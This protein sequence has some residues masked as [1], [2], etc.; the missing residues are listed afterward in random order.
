MKWNT[1]LEFGEETTQEKY[2]FPTDFQKF[3]AYAE[4]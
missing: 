2:E 4:I 1:T 3:E